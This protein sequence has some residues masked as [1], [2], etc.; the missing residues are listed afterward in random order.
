[1]NSAEYTYDSIRK[2]TFGIRGY[3]FLILMTAVYFTGYFF[4]PD[5][6][7]YLMFIVLGSVLL[8]AWQ[9]KPSFWLPFLP[10]L[11]LI[12]YPIIDLGLF[13]PSI[14]TLLMFAFTVWFIIDRI[15]WDE[16]VFFFYGIVYLF[17]AALLI[18]L[19]SIF[20][21]V[22][23]NGQNIWNAIRDGSGIFLFFPLIFI[24]PAICNSKNK[25][26]RLA[27]AI[28][29]TL[30]VAS[31]AGVIEYFSISGFSRIDLSLGY[32][33][34][35][36]VTGF[37]SNAN[38]F[39]GY[40]ELCIPVAIAMFFIEKKFLRKIL[41]LSAVILGFLS[42]LYTFSR[43][44]LLFV[45]IGSFLVLVFKF[46][47]NILVPIVLGALLLVLL[48]SNADVFERQVSFFTNPEAN[49]SQPTIIHR[50][51]TYRGY[52]NQF[53]ES[54]IFGIGW[55]AKE[56]FWG[57]T[58]IYSFWEVRHITS[59]ETIRHFGGLNSLFL[60][61]L[62]KGG[63]LSFLAVIFIFIAVFRSVYKAFGRNKLLA[64][65]IGGGI[66]AFMGHQLVDNLLQ[67]PQVNAVFWFLV[68]ILCAYAYP[69]FSQESDYE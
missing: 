21:S 31:L 8:I 52:L 39:A 56:F 11:F 28:V 45:V 62:V 22:H 44:G 5:N 38:V 59:T 1:M 27:R 63:L 34:K 53:S 55:G 33:Y 6:V 29:F 43:G 19:L 61:H 40:L 24:I 15:V 20:V 57:R 18:Q 67:W 36:R 9:P 17:C 37:F 4:L 32:L 23:L 14:A 54:P 41:S 69:S 50:Y 48:I 30:F 51:V 65:A 47:K 68:G 49:L 35:G 12:S 42:T 60:N 13:Y 3:L 2:Y 58:N 64:V 7:R 66:L 25:V 10:F 26:L 16:P 46:K